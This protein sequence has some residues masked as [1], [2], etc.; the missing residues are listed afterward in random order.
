MFNESERA[1]LAERKLTE[2]AEL[3][4]FIARVITDVHEA[5]KD[6]GK[7]GFL[8]ICKVAIQSIGDAKEALTGLEKIPA[9]MS[10]LDGGDVEALG[11]IFFPA[12]SQTQS[13]FTAALT[14]GALG[15]SRE[16]ANILA[17]LRAGPDAWNTPVKA[18]PVEE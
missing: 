11:A 15:T 16:I 12:I 8:E 7:I 18:Q 2:T 3:T 4:A 6:D 9:E 14:S 17:I 13:G 5:L 1:T 10:D